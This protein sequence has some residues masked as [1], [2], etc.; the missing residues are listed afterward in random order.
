MRLTYFGQ[1]AFQLDGPDGTRILIDPWIE[2][3]PGCD[4]LVESFTDVTAVLVTHAAFDHLGDAP[5]IARQNDAPLLCDY[6]TRTALQD[7][8]FP[9]ELLYGYIWGAEHGG[10]GWSTKVVEAR[11]MSYDE[12]ANLIGPA[13]AYIVT[14]DDTSIY[15]MG[16][17]SIFG[18]IEL[19]ADLYEPSVSLVPVGEAPGYFTELH[20]DEAALVAEWLNSDVTIPMHYPP[21]SDKP[22]KFREH[23]RERGVDEKTDIEILSAGS[24]LQ[25]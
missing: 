20:P 12:D 3:N 22:T 23:C 2:N 18:D 19:F 1:S 10:D 14:I 24:T 17:T 11:H 9:K 25:V 13:L 6:T 5:A 21:G 16:D 4:R 15:H 7:R 8:G